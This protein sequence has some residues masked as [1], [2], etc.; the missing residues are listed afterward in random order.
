MSCASSSRIQRIG[1]YIATLTLILSLNFFL[2]RL[3]PGD[4]FCELSSEEGQEVVR[5]TEEQ[6]QYYAEH[7]GLDLPLGQQF[8]SYLLALGKGDLGYSLYY[9]EAVDT[10]ILRRLPWT[11]GL[12]MSSMLL[13]TLI[14]GALGAVSAWNR[15]CVLDW[16]LYGPLV[17]LSEIPSF[18]LA[19]LLLFL[20]ATGIGLFPLAGAKSPFE[21]SSNLC[22]FISD[23]VHHAVLPVLALAV[24]RIGHMYLLTRNSMIGIIGADYMKTAQAKGLSRRRMIFRHALMNALPPIVTRLF[25]GLGG[26]MG[27]S[28]LVENVFT[29]PGIGTLLRDAVIS[30]DYPLI[31]GLFLFVAIFV[32]TANNLAD[33]ICHRLDPRIGLHGRTSG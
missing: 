9:N 13:S 20:L 7:Y 11:M 6:K 24:S 30:H 23:I 32:L 29:Y 1:E 22:Y 5:F 28:I 33:I 26:L 10:I 2:P 12:V 14:G 25:L 8:V 17:V 27:A 15:G 31:Q 3:M 18:L 21:T 4:P 19:L 16:I